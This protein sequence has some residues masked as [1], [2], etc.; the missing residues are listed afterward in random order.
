MPLL[1][2]KLINHYV[3]VMYLYN[4][5]LYPVFNNHTNDHDPNYPHPRVSVVVG[6]A[7]C[8]PYR[9]FL[10]WF[11]GCGKNRTMPRVS[12]LTWCTEIASRA[13]MWDLPPHKCVRRTSRNPN[14]LVADTVADK[15]WQE[16]RDE[17]RRVKVMDWDELHGEYLR[18]QAVGTNPDADD[19]RA[20]TFSPTHPHNWGSLQWTSKGMNE[21][22][23]KNKNKNNKGLAK[24]KW[25]WEKHPHR[26]WNMRKWWHP[27]TGRNW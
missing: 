13:L 12:L 26:K 15:C 5:K 23:R 24:K 20:G 16:R 14:S 9:Y 2:I 3:N 27:H 1:I 19:G 7:T 4:M 11:W 22:C 17:T 21:M 25:R 10:A 6:C 18:I 8:R